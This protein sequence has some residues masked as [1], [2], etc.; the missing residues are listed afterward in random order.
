MLELV[1]ESRDC[2]FGRMSTIIWES[3]ITFVLRAEQTG[4]RRIDEWIQMQG[5]TGKTA[6]T[7]LFVWT[8]YMHDKPV[9]LFLSNLFLNAFLVY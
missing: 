9:F 4:K 6:I 5:P 1:G 2:C 7:Q 8:Q 3:F